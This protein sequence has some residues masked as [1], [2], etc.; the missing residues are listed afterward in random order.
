MKL[1]IDNLSQIDLA[2][3]TLPQV[4]QRYG[5]FRVAR[6]CGRADGRAGVQTAI[7]D[8]LEK[9]WC[10]AVER[11]ALRE[12]ESWIVDCLEEDFKRNPCPDTRRKARREALILY[13]SRMFEDEM[14]VGYIPF[15]RKYCP[16]AIKEKHFVTV[17]AEC[18]NKPG[19]V[20]C[21]RFDSGDT[22]CP[23]CGRSI[24]VTEINEQE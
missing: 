13:A 23:V 16:D 24:K 12:Y 18:C 1:N 14:W 5:T 9:V 22:I 20:T 11:I 6:A 7:G 15:N 8:V 19:E 2:N 10:E 3:I 17:I 21:A 4:K